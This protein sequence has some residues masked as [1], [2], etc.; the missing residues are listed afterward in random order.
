MID[1]AVN[2][3]LPL[4]GDGAFIPRPGGDELTGARQAV[5][6]HVQAHAEAGVIDAA[7]DVALLLG[8]D[9][10]LVPRLGVS[11]LTDA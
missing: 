7:V 4:G 8:G 11:E 2:V 3:A 9:G 1:A 10:S 6:H 5:A